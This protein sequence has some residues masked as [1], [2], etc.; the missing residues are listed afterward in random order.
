MKHTCNIKQTDE[1]GDSR[2][3]PPIHPSTILVYAI[4]EAYRQTTYI[5]TTD[6]MSSTCRVS[7]IFDIHN[8]LY[9]DC[10]APTSQ[11]FAYRP[12]TQ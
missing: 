8:V 2:I 3:V 6:G 12:F 9:T 7:N 4:N 5:P 11:S 1:P 10:L